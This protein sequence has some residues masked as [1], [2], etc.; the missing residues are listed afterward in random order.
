MAQ[1]Q[2]T[3][4]GGSSQVDSFLPDAWRSGSLWVGLAKIQ[5]LTI[6]VVAQ[7][8]TFPQAD[9]LVSFLLLR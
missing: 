8:P 4:C 7:F 2:T 5:S 3:S 1:N 9:V 6:K